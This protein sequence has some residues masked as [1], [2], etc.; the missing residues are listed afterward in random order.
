M[1][2]DESQINEAR[3]ALGIRIRNARIDADLTQEGLFLEAGIPRSTY[4]NIERGDTDVRFGQLFRIAAVLR[5][6]V[7]DLLP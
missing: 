3:R 6:P 4:Q 5:V 1:H 2:V 7:R